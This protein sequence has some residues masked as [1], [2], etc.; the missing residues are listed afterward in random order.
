MGVVQ[1]GAPELWNLLAAAV[2]AEP[3]VTRSYEAIDR[4]HLNETP[5]GPAAR[6]WNPTPRRARPN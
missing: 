2:V 5:G 3:L 4:Y 6:A 1:D